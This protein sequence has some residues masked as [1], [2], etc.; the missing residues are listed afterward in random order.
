MDDPRPASCPGGL[1]VVATP[2]GNLEDITVRAIHTLSGVEL[3]A[4]EDTRHTSRLLAHY[5]IHTPLVSYHEHNEQQRTPQLIDKIRAGGAV[6]LVSDA[7]TPSVSDPGFR[8]VGAAI[9]NGLA[10]IPIPGVSAAVT[11]LSA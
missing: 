7:G 4:A 5:R 6:A 8:L 10:V 9:E 1:Y 11:A 3:I 2:I